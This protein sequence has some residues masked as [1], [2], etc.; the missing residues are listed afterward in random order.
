[1]KLAERRGGA[2][3]NRLE[4]SLLIAMD[5]QTVL[6]EKKNYV[7]ESEYD[8]IISRKCK[9]VLYLQKHY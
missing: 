9:D 8:A 6:K 2:D 1:M 3:P 7:E 5:E 4:A